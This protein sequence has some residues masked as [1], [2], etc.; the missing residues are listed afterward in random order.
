MEI[1]GPFAEYSHAE[2]SRY[3]AKELEVIYRFLERAIEITQSQ[4]E[5]IRPKEP[6][7]A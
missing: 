6:E 7:P 5:R 1:Y 4:L 3:T 2:F